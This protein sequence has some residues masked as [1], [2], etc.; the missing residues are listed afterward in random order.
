MRDRDIHTLVFVH[1][2][3]GNRAN[4]YPLQAYLWAKGHRRQYSFNYA[5]TDS[6]ESMGVRLQR[7]LKRDV[8]GGRIDIIAHSMGG[9]VSRVYLQMLGGDR[10]VDR[11]ITLGTPHR[12]SYASSWLPTPL[13]RQLHPDGPF[14]THLNGLAAPD[15]TTT[16]IAASQDILV[17][18]PRHALA[19]FGETRMLDDMGHNQMLFSPTVFGHVHDAIGRHPPVPEPAWTPSMAAPL[20]LAVR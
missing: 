3:G 6:I 15:V 20:R 2:L 5:M 8:R 19:P 18:P 1:G 9:L 12:G 4:F 7:L 10:R 14:L 11:F 13:V 16:S 17:L